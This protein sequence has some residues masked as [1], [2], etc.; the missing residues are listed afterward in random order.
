MRRI[1]ALRRERGWTLSELSHRAKLH[2][3]TLSMIE[4]GRLNPY[5]K[6]LRKIGRALGVTDAAELD[7]LLA[8]VGNDDG[9]R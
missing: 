6:Q 8:E 2:I 5:P 1:E 3:S 7:S 4:S 9:A